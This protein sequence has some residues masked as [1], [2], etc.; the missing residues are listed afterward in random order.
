VRAIQVHAS[1][2]VVQ[3]LRDLGWIVGRNLSIDY[4]YITGGSQSFD[5]Q[6]AELIALAPDV[7]LVNN[8]PA[9]RAL[10]QATSTLPIVFALVLD[11]VASGVVTNRH[12]SAALPR[13]QTRSGC[14]MPMT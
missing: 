5:A 4:R 13:L 2:P 12:V 11:P 9:T 1:G 3:A 10:Q 7:L 8:T 6:A 14:N